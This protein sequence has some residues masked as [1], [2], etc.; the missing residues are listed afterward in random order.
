LNFLPQ[1]AFRLF[2]SSIAAA[3]AATLDNFT[4]T[5]VPEPAALPLLAAGAGLFLLRRRR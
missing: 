1:V 3:T 2:D 5:V 4:V